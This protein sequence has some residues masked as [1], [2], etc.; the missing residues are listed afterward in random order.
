M[1][2]V[3]VYS[4]LLFLLLLCVPPALAYPDGGRKVCATSSNATDANCSKAQAVLK[5]GLI[6]VKL[7]FNGTAKGACQLE[8]LGPLESFPR[9]GTLEFDVAVLISYPNCVLLK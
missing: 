1:A 3:R 6:F 8:G 2:E 9:C 5:G 4:F 7:D